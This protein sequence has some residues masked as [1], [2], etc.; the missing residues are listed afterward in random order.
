MSEVARAAREQNGWHVV[1]R[2]I[3]PDRRGTVPH[4]IVLFEREIHP[5]VD[6]AFGTA[7]YAVRESGISFYS[8]HYDLDEEEAAADFGERMRATRFKRIAPEYQR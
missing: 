1:A 3:G 7:E 4:G 8:G 2:S 5:F 6:K